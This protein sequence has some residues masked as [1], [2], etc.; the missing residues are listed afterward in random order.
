M[1]FSCLLSLANIICGPQRIL[2]NKKKCSSRPL[3]KSKI[4]KWKKTLTK[5]MPAVGHVELCV[6]KWNNSSALKNSNSSA[7]KLNSSHGLRKRPHVRHRSP[8]GNSNPFPSQ[9]NSSRFVPLS[10]AIYTGSSPLPLDEWNAFERCHRHRTEAMVS[11]SVSLLWN[12][13][14][15]LF[16]LF[17]SS[18]ILNLK[19]K[20]S[21]YPWA[22]SIKFSDNNWKY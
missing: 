1:F 3:W 11:P 7:V 5:I 14:C 12:L 9:S 8:E 6:F 17:S 16:W 15:S 4:I 18:F 2:L 19:L 10:A 13:P 21:L 22:C 20:V